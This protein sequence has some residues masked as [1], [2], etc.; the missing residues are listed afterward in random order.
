MIFAAVKEN[1]LTAIDRVARVVR[2]NPKSVDILQCVLVESHAGDIYISAYSPMASARVKVCDTA[3]GEPGSF[4][5]NLDKFKDRVSKAGS[6]IKLQ[7]DVTGLKLISSDDQRLGLALNN[8]NEYPTLE[9]E[10]P[11]ETYGL[12]RDEVLELFKSA[13]SLSGNNTSLIPAFLQVVIR[14]Q[15]MWAANGV[16]YFKFPIR[17]NPELVASIPTQTLLAISGFIQE[18]DA[19]TVWISQD[20]Y[21]DLVVSVG[22]DQFQASPLAVSFPDLSDIFN[23]VRISSIQKLTVSRAK[24]ADELMKAKTSTNSHG[25]VTLTVGG[26]ALSKIDIRAESDSGDWYES[27]VAASWDGSVESRT[28]VFNADSLRK[29]LNQF[30]HDMID[31]MVGD[32]FKGDLSPIYVEEGEKVGI[33]NQFRI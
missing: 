13:H 19:D 3:L 23:Q 31:I 24:L 27:T 12:H 10:Y 22:V 9:W 20:S 7:A 5:V 30:D 14:D 1:L 4:L 17:C 29:F 8:I 25:C 33:L 15:T 26:L 6:R 18:T 2:A 16:A 28:L 32:D 11:D 21:K